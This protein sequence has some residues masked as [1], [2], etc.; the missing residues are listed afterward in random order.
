MKVVI[1]NCFGGFGLSHEAMMRYGEIKG[2]KFYPE[3]V[4]Y[5]YYIYWL[6]P[7]EARIATVE[8]VKFYELSFEDR[9]A[10]NEQYSKQTIYDRDIARDDPVLIQVV[11]E[12]GKKASG[13]HAELKIVQIPDDVSWE[14]EE[15]DGN[16]HIAETHR[17]WS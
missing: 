16:E 7:P 5:G 1:N 8:G 17:T 9:K 13:A 12:L 6:T 10:Y 11:E 2:I 15:Y 14:I 4:S 3:K